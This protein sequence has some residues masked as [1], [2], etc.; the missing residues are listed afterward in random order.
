MENAFTK[1]ESKV[2]ADL[3]A[4]GLADV[5]AGRF[6]VFPHSYLEFFLANSQSWAVA[7]ALSVLAAVGANFAPGIRLA[8]LVAEIVDLQEKI[9]KDNKKIN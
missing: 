7:E 4:K 2:Q 1:L 5:L 6:I 9:A 8:V 3:A